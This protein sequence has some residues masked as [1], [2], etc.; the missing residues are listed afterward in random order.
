ML[1][2]SSFTMFV[3]LAVCDPVR[4]CVCPDSVERDRH[5]N[6]SGRRAHSSQDRIGGARG[7]FRSGLVNTTDHC[8]R[9]D[10]VRNICWSGRSQSLRDRICWIFSLLHRGPS[11]VRMDSVDHGSDG[12]SRSESQT[13]TTPTVTFGSNYAGRPGPSK[14]SKTYRSKLNPPSQFL[15]KQARAPQRKSAYKLFC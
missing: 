6:G 4:E 5:R 15:S 1:V 13:E 8:G 11:V 7:A 10:P 2:R 3:G 14:F 9:L 12:G